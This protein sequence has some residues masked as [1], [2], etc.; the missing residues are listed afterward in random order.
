MLLLTYNDKR[1]ALIVCIYVYVCVA[2]HMHSPYYCIY[3]D[4][5]LRS[6]DA[7]IEWCSPLT[8]SWRFLH[9]DEMPRYVCVCTVMNMLREWVGRV[10]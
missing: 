1:V 8:M 3:V 6:A 4:H 2:S 10:E 7:M 5:I 9:L